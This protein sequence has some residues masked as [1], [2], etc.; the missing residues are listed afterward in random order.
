MNLLPQLPR[1]LRALLLS[2]NLAA[3]TAVTAWFFEATFPNL[4]A[5]WVLGAAAAAVALPLTRLAARR[6]DERQENL[7]RRA[8]EHAATHLAEQ[9]EVT[10]VHVAD[11]ISQ[12]AAALADQIAAVHVRLDALASS[13]TQD[14]DPHETGVP[15]AD[16]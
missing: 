2:V 5:S 10:R 15:D 11:Q 16:R 9:H 13:A 3:S 12:H 7:A 1:W 4:I 8:A 14:P 6:L